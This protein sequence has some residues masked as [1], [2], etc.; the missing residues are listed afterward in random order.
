MAK[1]DIVVI[2][3]TVLHSPTGTYQ[4][5]GRRSSNRLLGIMMIEAVCSCEIAADT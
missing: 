1:F 4:N 5:F 2:C 3:V